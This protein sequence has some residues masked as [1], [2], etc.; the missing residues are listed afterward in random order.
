MNQHLQSILNLV[1]QESILSNEQKVA[2]AKALKNADKDLEISAFKL[3]RTEKVKRTTAILLEET[4]E[5]LELKRKAVEE[6]NSALTT[7]MI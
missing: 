1:E 4:I 6:S 2:I 5:E 3:D 7:C